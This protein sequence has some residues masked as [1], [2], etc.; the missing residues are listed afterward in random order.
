MGFIDRLVAIHLDKG[1]A[2]EVVYYPY[3]R[4]GR[5][6][7]VPESSNVRV[8]LRRF[9]VSAISIFFSAYLFLNGAERILLGAGLLLT[10][11]V[12]NRF[13]LKRLRLLE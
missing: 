1:P 8:F 6:Y 5:G 12:G 2:G 13:F 7:I 3:G 9:Y 11:W 10:F 4:D